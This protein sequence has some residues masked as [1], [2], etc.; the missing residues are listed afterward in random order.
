MVAAI[1]PAYRL[2]KTSFRQGQSRDE[3]IDA[4]VVAQVRLTVTA[5]RA[6]PLIGQSGAMVTGGR[7]SLTTGVVTPDCPS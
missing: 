5:L 1:A 7:Y 2:A 6:E 4:T 3:R